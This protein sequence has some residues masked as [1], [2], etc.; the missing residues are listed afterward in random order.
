MKFSIL[1]FGQQSFIRSVILCYTYFI[2]PPRP[3]P[4]RMT[5]LPFPSTTCSPLIRRILFDMVGDVSG[6]WLCFRRVVLRKEDWS[7]G[8]VLREL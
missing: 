1:E 3:A 4:R 6:C 8:V 5:E 7:H 2:H